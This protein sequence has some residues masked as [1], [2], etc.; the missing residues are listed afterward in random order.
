MPDTVRTMPEQIRAGGESEKDRMQNMD[1]NNET[2][3]HGAYH[4]RASN[5][6]SAA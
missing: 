1:S 5:R 3:E 6:S 4:W 2:G